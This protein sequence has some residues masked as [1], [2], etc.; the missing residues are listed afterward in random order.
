MDYRGRQLAFIVGHYKSGSSWLAYLLC[1]HPSIRGLSE[2]HIFRHSAAGDL[3]ECTAQLYNTVAWAGGGRRKL[4]RHRLASWARPFRRHGQST[5]SWKE[6]PTTLLDLSIR[7][8]Y[9]LHKMLLKQ[10]DKDAYRIA[11]FEYL[12]QAL[13]PPAYLLEKTPTNIYFVPEIRRLFPDSKLIAIYRD[14]RDV[15]VSDRHHSRNAY[16]EELIFS[17]SVGNWKKAI[18]AQLEYA[19]KYNMFVLSYEE[20]KRDSRAM[21]ERLLMFLGLDCDF[22]IVEDMVQ[23][24]SFEFITGRR[25]GT[26]SERSFFRK[27]IVGDWRNQLSYEECRLFSAIAGE[28][29][30]TLGY[31]QSTDPASWQSGLS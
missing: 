6:R 31:E 9:L 29:L 8:Q 2:T 4:F 14:G 10:T 15:A 25:P 20:L 18:E 3:T 26:E 22:A 7:D 28:M 13:R 11:F 23:R 24:S 19:Q 5:L 16:Q 27:G 12:S 21:T 1:L 17:E 30:V